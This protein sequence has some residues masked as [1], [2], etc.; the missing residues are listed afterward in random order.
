MAGYVLRLADEDGV[1]FLANRILT[2]QTSAFVAGI[3]RELGNSFLVPE[4]LAGGYTEIEAAVASATNDVYRLVMGDEDGIPL[5][6]AEA[7]LDVTISAPVDVTPPTWSV[8]P[9]VASVQFSGHTTSFTLSENGRVYIVAVPHGST[10]P[11]Y[12][13]VKGGKQ[14]GGTAALSFN[15]DE[16]VVGGASTQISIANVLYD[17]GNIRITSYDSYVAAEDTAGNA[18]SVFSLGEVTIDAPATFA[19]VVTGSVN[20][21]LHQVTLGWNAA[22]DSVDLSEEISYI[23][24]YDVGNGPVI[25]T[26]TSPG[27]LSVTF[28]PGGEVT[29]QADYSVL[30]VNTRGLVDTNSATISLTLG[31][32]S[33]QYQVTTGI[34]LSSNSPLAN[35]AVE[36]MWLPVDDFGNA[37]E[38]TGIWISGTT[39]AI[40]VLTVNVSTT[41]AGNLRVRGPNGEAWEAKNLTPVGV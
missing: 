11:T 30:S 3:V 2:V 41:T 9:A 34:L 20:T 32:G 40:G 24:R 8:N 33:G 14:S 28:D 4:I 35:T 17:S 36:Y 16:A 37:Q 6:D 23:A 19:G 10:A 31:S 26:I 38:E 1:P 12:A 27:A 29:G 7:D 22:S 21:A 5:A 13:E 25:A 15:K 39:N 18:M